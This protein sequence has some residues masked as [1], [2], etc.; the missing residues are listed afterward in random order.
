MKRIRVNA[1]VLAVKESEV[2]KGRY[3]ITAKAEGFGEVKYAGTKNHKVGDKVVLQDQKLRISSEGI[4][5]EE[6]K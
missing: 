2:M 3:Y 1:E 6:T 5:W 4:R